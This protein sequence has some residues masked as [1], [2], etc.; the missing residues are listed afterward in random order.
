MASYYAYLERQKA[1]QGGPN[2]EAHRTANRPPVQWRRDR[3][4]GSGDSEPPVLRARISGRRVDNPR[5]DRSFPTG[6]R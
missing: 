1:L 4:D 2:A 5:K 3:A 6:P